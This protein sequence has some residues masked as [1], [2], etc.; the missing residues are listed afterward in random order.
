MITSEEFLDWLEP[1]IH[2]DLID[3][4]IHMHSPVHYNHARLVSFLDR[5]LASFL[6]EMEIPGE[7]H[8]E[9]MAIR[10]NVRDTFMPDLEFFA[11]HQVAQFADCCVPVAPIFCVEVLSPSTAKNDLGRKFTAYEAHAVQEYWVLDP[12]K[13]Q[14]RFFRRVGGLFVE[15]GMKDERIESVSIPGFWLRRAWLD[16]EKLPR[17]STCAAEIVKAAR[18]RR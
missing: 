6:D 3:G 17:V 18:R 10:L 14:H 9:T 11:P 2:A 5:L 1:G 16:P 13:A 7:L 8:R 15:F 12:A 4:E